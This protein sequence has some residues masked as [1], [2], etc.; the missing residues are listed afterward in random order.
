MLALVGANA[1]MARRRKDEREREA[2]VRVIVTC[3]IEN[4]DYE[5]DCSILNTKQQLEELIWKTQCFTWPGV[6][7]SV[8]GDSNKEFLFIKEVLD[9]KLIATRKE[10][11]PGCTCVVL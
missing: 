6:Q 2:K 4:E 1:I 5:F 11:V 10:Q 3:T 9:K 8:V 7:L